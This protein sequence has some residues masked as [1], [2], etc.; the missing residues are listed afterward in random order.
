MLYVANHVLD[1]L[2]LPTLEH[3]SLDVAKPRMRVRG[4][5]RSADA[6]ALRVSRSAVRELDQ[7]T[8]NWGMRG[9]G[10]ESG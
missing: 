7:L 6:E 1:W 3:G 9:K 10:P 8:Q 4:N 2:Y 5:V